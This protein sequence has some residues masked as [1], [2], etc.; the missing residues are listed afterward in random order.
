MF[1]KKRHKIKPKK[2]IWKSKFFWVVILIL[3]LACASVYFLIFFPGLQVKN[4]LISGNEKVK[5]E[6]LMN[7]AVTGVK[8]ELLDFWGVKIYTE[9][10]FLVDIKSLDEEISKKYPVIEK[11][12]LSRSFP[13]TLNLGVA[14]RKPAGIYCSDRECFLID[15]NGVIFE[16]LSAV[17]QGLFIVRQVLK[18]TQDFTGENVIDK[19]IMDAL[20]KIGRELQEKF[21]IDIK[22]ALLAESINSVKIDIKTSEGWNIYFGLGPDYQGVDQ[23]MQKMTLLLQK[24]VTESERKSLQYINLMYKDRASYK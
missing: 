8:T 12:S 5:T 24:Q 4:I 2:Q 1:Y 11:V 10:I 20:I 16:D 14:E 17:P 23:Q 21:Q 7:L 9:S 6:D 3:V 19:N 22:E 15:S 13:Q 18:T